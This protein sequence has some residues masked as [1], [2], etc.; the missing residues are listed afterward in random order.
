MKIL[1]E[2]ACGTGHN[3]VSIFSQNCNKSECKNSH[4]RNRKLRSD[5][6]I[7]HIK[8]YSKILKLELI[9]SDSRKGNYKSYEK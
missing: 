4:T 8:H 7:F 6:E 5:F 1:S 3:N 2:I 9:F